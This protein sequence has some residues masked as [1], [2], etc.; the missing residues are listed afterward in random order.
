M[1]GEAD[2]FRHTF[3]P[4]GPKEFADYVKAE[5]VKWGKIVKAGNIRAE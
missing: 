2:P 4:G 5:V 1:A 3:A